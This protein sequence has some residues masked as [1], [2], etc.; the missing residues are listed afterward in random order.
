MRMTSSYPEVMRECLHRGKNLLSGLD[1]PY[2]QTEKSYLIVLNKLNSPTLQLY[3]KLELSSFDLRSVCFIKIHH[4]HE[5]SVGVWKHS[6]PTAI[7]CYLLHYVQFRNR[8]YA[9]P[10]SDFQRV[11][12]NTCAPC[13]SKVNNLYKPL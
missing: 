6:F 11:L 12:S 1:S 9:E 13:C 8:W 10:L 7:S 3:G 5:L 2:I 4:R